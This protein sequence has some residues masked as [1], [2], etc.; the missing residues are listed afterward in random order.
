MYT[1]NVIE[2]INVINAIDAINV[3]KM[4]IDSEACAKKNIKMKENIKIKENEKIKSEQLA[5]QTTQEWNKLCEELG[6][7]AKAPIYLYGGDDGDDLQEEFQV[8][9]AGD[10]ALI[11]VEQMRNEALFSNESF[12]GEKT[13]LLE[14]IDEKLEEADRDYPSADFKQKLTTLCRIYWYVFA[15]DESRGRISRLPPVTCELIDGAPSYLNVKL[16]GCGAE[17]EKWMRGKIA[18][19]VEM[20]QL[21]KVL[22][23]DYSCAARV[24]TKKGPVPFRMIVDMRPLNEITKKTALQLPL[25]EQQLHRCSGA[26]YFGTFDVKSGY[27]FVPVDEKAKKYFHLTTPWGEVYQICGVPQG[28]VN[29]PMLF[30]QTL[31]QVILQVTGYYNMDKN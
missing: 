13:K 7:P 8:G 26:R 27:D 28:W 24:T 16:Q 22:K 15:L 21:Q 14:A 1:R 12:P 3:C 18:M 23:A 11:L 25:L 17:Q 2:D 5:A 9:F 20:K 29:S 4:E 31:V 19:M 10:S 30:H 6:L